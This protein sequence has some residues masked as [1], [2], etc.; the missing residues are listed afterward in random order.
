MLCRCSRLRDP[1][2]IH[3]AN[4]L[5]HSRAHDPRRWMSCTDGKSGST[6]VVEPRSPR[7][8]RMAPR[9]SADGAIRMHGVEEEE[10]RESRYEQIGDGLECLVVVEMRG[11]DLTH[12]GEEPFALLSQAQRLLARTDPQIH[13]LQLGV[14]LLRG[15]VRRLL[16]S[17]FTTALFS[18]YTLGNVDAAS[19]EPEKASVVVA[20]RN[21]P[22]QDPA[23]HSVV[24]LEPI[25]HLER[26]SLIEIGDVDV[27]A[28]CEVIGMHS[29]RPAVAGL[30]GKGSSRELQPGV[31]EVV[32]L[33]VDI[34]APDH[35]RR[36]LHEQPILD[37]GQLLGRRLAEGV[38]TNGSGHLLRPHL[39]SRVGGAFL[40]LFR[41]T[42]TRQ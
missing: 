22:I 4:E 11:H 18:L 25:L 10:I 5:G 27:E 34:G 28:P 20:I 29:L 9:E 14:L 21:A 40:R 31:V 1:A 19:D 33:L 36:V 8:I 39:A 41:W 38:W 2:F 42:N 26:H 3:F 30:L 23:V 17:Q 7:L 16:R 15:R 12:F 6:Y 13:F 35:H 24:A 37:G 32:A